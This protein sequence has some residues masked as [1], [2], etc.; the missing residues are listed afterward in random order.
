[1]HMHPLPLG[2]SKTHWPGRN[3]KV[4]KQPFY[5]QGSVPILTLA[6]DFFGFPFSYF[7]ALGLTKR[8]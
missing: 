6:A 3:N 5:C 7:H 4:G 1:M 8:A 2:Q